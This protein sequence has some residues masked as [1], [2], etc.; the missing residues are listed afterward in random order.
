MGDN[1]LIA[2][3]III[4]VSLMIFGAIAGNAVIVASCTTSLVTANVPAGT[5]TMYG[6]VALIGIVAI[7][8]AYLKFGVDGR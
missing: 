3:I 8:M 5:I 4:V 7:V 6:L 1:T 2:G